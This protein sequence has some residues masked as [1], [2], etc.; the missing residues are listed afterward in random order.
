MLA[1]TQLKEPIQDGTISE[2]CV[3]RIVDS[4]RIKNH[5]QIISFEV[6]ETP[7]EV[8]GNP[9]PLKGEEKVK[10][11]VTVKEEVAVKAESSPTKQEAV[12]EDP[13]QVEKKPD[14]GSPTPKGPALT[15]PAP[16]PP[17]A[18]AGSPISMSQVISGFRLSIPCPALT[19]RVL[20]CQSAGNLMPI[21]QLNPYCSCKIKGRVVTKVGFFDACAL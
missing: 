10:Q 18:E 2:N 1:A 16:S 3:M 4:D 11:E 14:V 13:M 19:Q 9:V 7:M 21:D 5:V 12:T 8:I 17:K 15:S 20:C 6:L